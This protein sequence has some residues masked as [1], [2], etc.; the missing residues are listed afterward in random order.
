MKRYT[1]IDI[2]R[3][4]GI[5]CVIMG[6]ALATGPKALDSPISKN[7]FDLIYSFH[8]PLLMIIAG[9]ALGISI[10]KR[11]R[12]EL[13]IKKAQRL[14]I[15]Y[16]T[17]GILYFLMKTIIAKTKHF[18]YN[19]AKN[20]WKMI[21]GINPSFSLWFLYVLFLLSVLVI[22]VTTKKNIIVLAIIATVVSCVFANNR[23]CEYVCYIFLGVL[24][25]TFY[26]QVKKHLFKWYI[27]IFA[28]IVF[29][30]LFIVRNNIKNTILYNTANVAMAILAS[31]IVLAFSYYLSKCKSGLVKA[32]IVIGKYSMDI[33][34]IG[35]LTQPMLKILFGL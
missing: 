35:S 20:L 24:L 18:E 9:F 22:M 34:I 10:N 5:V 28:G 29:I 26:D 6:H 16:F 2:A 12:K 7:L 27:Q 21:I 3:G 31:I 11:N 17:A 25:Y 23:I 14:L 33:Y 8:M 32:P 19:E 1:E 4:I 15:P 30:A 13:I